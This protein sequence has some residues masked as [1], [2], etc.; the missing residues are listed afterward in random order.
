MYICMCVR[1]CYPCERFTEQCGLAACGSQAICFLQ[2]APDI[3]M[4]GPWEWGWLPRVGGGVGLAAEGAVCVGME[5]GLEWLGGR[6]GR[7][8]VCA[9]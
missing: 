9:C 5:W 3:L 8:V 4:D 7:W 6:A 1:V 2:L